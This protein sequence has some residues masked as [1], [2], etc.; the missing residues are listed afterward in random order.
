MTK[1]YL[2]HSLHNLCCRMTTKET[3]VSFVVISAE[4]IEVPLYL[5][6]ETW[7]Y[8][9]KWI[10]CLMSAA[11]LFSLVHE[12]QDAIFCNVMFAWLIHGYLE[13]GMAKF[14]T[15]ALVQQRPLLYMNVSVAN[16]VLQL[17]EVVLIFSFECE[18]WQLVVYLMT[19]GLMAAG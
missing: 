19:N 8:Y 12:E 10:Q 17:M 15:L 16:F 11:V 4:C 6:W 3:D 2:S 14:W 1:E 9:L 13:L 5:Q 18:T 7:I